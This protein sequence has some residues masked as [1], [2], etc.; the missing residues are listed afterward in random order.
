MLGF[1]GIRIGIYGE[2]EKI[3]EV[4]DVAK[5][6]GAIEASISGLGKEPT[7]TYANNEAFHVAAKG[8]GSPE[9]TL[10][11]LNLPE[12]VVQKALGVTVENGI[13][14]VG[15]DTKPP[16]VSVVLTGQDNDGKD[17]H[18]ALLKGVLT[19]PE[20]S[21]ATATDSDEPTPTELTGK[22]IARKSDG[23]V[24]AKGREAAE[25]FTKEEFDAL[26]FQGY[27]SPVPVGE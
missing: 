15:K 18:I 27:S 14:K 3:V 9:L 6:G 2:G 8:A 5:E 20:D 24:Y 7:I 11:T 19:Y 1:N 17:L 10:S 23:L 21:L 16:F 26:V 13:Q 4:L 12:E 25:G 22:F